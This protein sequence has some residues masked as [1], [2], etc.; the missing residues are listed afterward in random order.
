MRAI[1]RDILDKLSVDQELKAYDSE[2]W[3]VFDDENNVSCTAEVMMNSDADELTADIQF[4]RDFPKGDEKPM[5]QV[6]HII[7][8][9]AVQGKWDIKT[10]TFKGE[11]RGGDSYNWEGKCAD[12]FSACVQELKM[13]K[14]PD[15]DALAEK[16]L[17][18]D[19]RFGGT[20]GGG[21]RK[22]PQMKNQNNMK[23]KSGM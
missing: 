7:A 20:K 1:L 17:K 8:V 10:A 13:D 4:M 2:S 21:G 22:S 12:L 6:L 16:E 14:I 15:I 3:A 19:E 23:M 18:D 5:E 11:N 9:P